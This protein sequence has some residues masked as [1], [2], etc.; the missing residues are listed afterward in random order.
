MARFCDDKLF[1]GGNA[2]HHIYVPALVFSTLV[3]SIDSHTLYG[4]GLSFRES[5]TIV[6]S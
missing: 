1:A 4:V 5:E 3:D 2:T 6:Y